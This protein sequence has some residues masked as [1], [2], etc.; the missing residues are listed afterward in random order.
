[1]DSSKCIAK[2]TLLYAAS[3]H[4]SARR[5]KRKADLDD[6]RRYDASRDDEL[7]QVSCSSLATAA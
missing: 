1:M 4:P 3:S 2:L 5:L 7:V 6:G